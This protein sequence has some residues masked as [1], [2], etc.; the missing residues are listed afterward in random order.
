M[1]KSSPGSIYAGAMRSGDR[2]GRM[3]T[4]IAETLLESLIANRK[5]LADSGKICILD[6]TFGPPQLLPKDWEQKL[7]KLCQI[8]DEHSGTLITVAQHA[9]RR[10]EFDAKKQSIQISYAYE[11]W[12]CDGKDDLERHHKIA[13]WFGGMDEPANLV[14]LCKDCHEV[15]SKYESHFLRQIRAQQKQAGLVAKFGAGLRTLSL[16]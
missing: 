12:V 15:P 8:V 16:E 3:P 6:D 5:S 10:Q 2:E 14:W 4:V 1:L 9:I 13:I 7:R 11:C